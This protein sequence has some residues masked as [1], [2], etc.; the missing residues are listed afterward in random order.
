MVEAAVQ[1]RH[2]RRPAGHPQAAATTKV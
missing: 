2:Q 1:H